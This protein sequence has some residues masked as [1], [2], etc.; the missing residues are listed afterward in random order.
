MTAARCLRPR[1][2][3]ALQEL[4]SAPRPLHFLGKT[5]RRKETKIAE[6]KRSA[7]F[8]KVQFRCEMMTTINLL[9]G[10]LL[11][12]HRNDYFLN[13]SPS[14]WVSI[15]VSLSLSLRSHRSDGI[16]SHVAFDLE[17]GVK[18]IGASCQPIATVVAERSKRHRVNPEFQNR[19][20]LV[21]MHSE[22]TNRDVEKK[23][24]SFKPQFKYQ[25]LCIVNNYLIFLSWT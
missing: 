4:A 5:R 24:F 3:S 2:D 20:A 6:E 19:R 13:H 11:F 1:A 12:S 23:T 16:A 15:A 18:F 14:R 17:K 10:L 7:E 8:S 9:T 22:V 25:I 21:K